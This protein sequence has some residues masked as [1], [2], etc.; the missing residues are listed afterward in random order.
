MENLTIK[1]AILHFAT[2]FN[3]AKNYNAMFE[4]SNIPSMINTVI[5]DMFLY[6][7]CVETSEDLD[8]KMYSIIYQNFYKLKSVG[9]L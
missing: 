3:L 8:R 6:K 2:K 7:F 9:F 4:I 1:D 5:L